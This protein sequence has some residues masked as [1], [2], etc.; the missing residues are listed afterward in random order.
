[1]TARSLV[2]LLLAVCLQTPLA[3][4]QQVEVEEFVL[5]NGMK[6]LLLPRHEQPNTI[7]AGWVA[8]VGSVNE[9]PG[10]TGISHFF[11]HMMCKGTDTIGTRDPERDAKIRE[12]QNQVR[13]RMNALIWGDQ[14]ERYFKGEIEDPW[15]AANDTE[16]LAGLRAELKGLMEEQQGR[17]NAS[18]IEEMRS[19]LGSVEDEDTRN[20]LE[21][22][23]DEMEVEQE[24]EGVYTA[25]SAEE[26]E[27]E[28]GT[29]AAQRCRSSCSF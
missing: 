2:F 10:I 28:T 26:E 7:T 13:D 11:E 24:S 18:R 22:A 5:P 4:A 19:Q 3:S 27:E 6:F 20:R 14:Y 16:E 9:R 21:L 17:A 1:M 12:R 25:T 8:K 15:D 29:A 23:I